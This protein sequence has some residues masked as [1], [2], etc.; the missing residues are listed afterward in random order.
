[1]RLLRLVTLRVQEM[2]RVILWAI[3]KEIGFPIN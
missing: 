2:E 1:M 3:Q